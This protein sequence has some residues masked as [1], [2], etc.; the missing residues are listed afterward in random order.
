MKKALFFLETGATKR[1]CNF[2]A[3]RSKLLLKSLFRF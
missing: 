3:A 2:A 1:V